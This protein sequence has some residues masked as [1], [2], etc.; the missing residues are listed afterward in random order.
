MKIG[1]V[2][3]DG[4]TISGH[5]GKAR[6]FVVY[7]LYGEEARGREY[8]I[9]RGGNDGR[10][11]TCRHDRIIDTVKDCQM[12]VAGGMGRRILEDLAENGIQAILTDETVIKEALDKFVKGTITN[13]PERMH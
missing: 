6:G 4:E 2:S 1:F 8:R 5:F 12:V 13:H 10:C 9:N 3:D 11:G 7:E